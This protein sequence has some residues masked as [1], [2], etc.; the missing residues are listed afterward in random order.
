MLLKSF[1]RST[2][3]MGNLPRMQTLPLPYID[4]Y[5][6]KCQE[7][8]EKYSDVIDWLGGLDERLEVMVYWLGLAS[9]CKSAKVH[10]YLSGKKN[11]YK[12]ADNQKHFLKCFFLGYVNS[13]SCWSQMNNSDYYM[14]SS[15]S[16]QDEPNPALWLA[17]RAVKMELSCPLG[18]TRRVPQET[19]RRKPYN[20]SSIDQAFSVKMAGYWPRSFFCVIMDRDYVSVHKNEEKELGQYPAILTSHL[21]NYPYVL[22]HWARCM[23]LWVFFFIRLII[24]HLARK[25]VRTFVRGHHFFWPA[26]SFLRTQ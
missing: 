12:F 10:F 24:L 26:N 9:P 11:G 22:N 23:S 25:F 19:F 15:A 21:V 8:S 13:W 2:G 17:T 16:G 7:F 3:L 14:A 18:T 4:H 6:W 1:G 5:H 20:K